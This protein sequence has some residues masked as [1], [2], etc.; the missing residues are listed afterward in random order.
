MKRK[1]QV[2]LLSGVKPEETDSDDSDDY[3]YTIKTEAEVINTVKQPLPQVSLKLND[4]NMSLLIDTG[5]TV[6]I[7]DEAAYQKLGKPTLQRS[8]EPNLYPYGT[9]NP[10]RI[11]GQCELLLGTKHKIQ[12]HTFFVT[13]GNHGSLIGYQTAQALSLVKV[14]QNITDPSSRYPYL[15]KGIGKLK[16][17]QVKIHID[18]SVK[19]V[20]QKPRRVP[21]PLGD[22][23]EQEIDRLLEEDII[24]KV[25]GDPTPWVSPI[26]VVPKKDSKSVRV[27]VDMRKANQAIVRERHQ[28]PTVE[29]LT[30]DLNGAKI[31]SKIDLTS[32]YHQ[33][34]L[35]KESRSITTFSTHVGLFRYK[36]L[37][38]GIS[39]ASEIFQETIRSVIQDIPNARNISDDI[40]VFGTT[41]EQHDKTLEAVF[42][43]LHETGLTINKSKCLFNQTT[44][45]FFGL[46]FSS[47][48]VS[49]D[50]S[51]VTAIKHA[52]KPTNVAEIKSFLGMT[53]YCS[54]FIK[55]YATISEPLRRLTKTNTPW[56]WSDEQE[57][58]FLSLKDSLTSNS[59]MRYFDPLK[60][61]TIIVDAS[62]VGLGGILTQ[63]NHVLSYASR[64]LTEVESRYSQTER[65]ALAI[66]WACEHFDMYTNG[67]QHFT[68]ITDHKPLENIWQKTNPTPRIQRLGLRLQ[69]Y[70]FTIS[71]Q[72]GNSNPSDY[73][74]R[75]PEPND[76]TC[77]TKS[78]QE[79]VAE[80][81]VNFLAITSTPRSMS[82]DDIK[83]ETQKDQ[84]MQKVMSLVRSSRWHEIKTINDPNIDMKELQL[85]YNVRDELAC[86]T[87]NILLRNN[88]I[89]IPS[90]L[91]CQA[92]D[93]AH[94]GHQGINRT[95]SL[96]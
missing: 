19:P 78:L 14:F 20:A 25:Q 44:I 47:D 23:V 29:E 91:R 60:K 93:I 51:K 8:K 87:N 31:F 96:I 5:S 30:S 64:S 43:R 69:P 58:A 94:E 76:Q 1:Q 15:F 83:N 67:A 7:I 4:I 26:V 63:D 80:Q 75:H 89:V 82:L 68:V 16:N 2:K 11:L 45:E 27:C 37:N 49:P 42:R 81:Y 13:K 71:Y 34:E 46:V 66:V 90:S 36:R 53:S 41:Q 72:P 40:I 21:F 28:M 62:P 59:V 77:S 32:G 39:S 10:L 92:I 95:K 12:C 52:T 50:P 65:E 73:L 85:F 33:L 22:Q 24:E 70:K 57:T 54:R 74:S 9:N 48:G 56:C 38:F 18:E 6:N 3:C 88:L 79:R 17:T 35:T 84:T 86:H 61:L 55:D